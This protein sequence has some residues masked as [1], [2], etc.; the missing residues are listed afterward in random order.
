ME[1]EESSSWLVKQGFD[2]EP[3]KRKSGSR[4][5]LIERSASS[6]LY[7]LLNSKFHHRQLLFLVHGEF[8]HPSHLDAEHLYSA[9]LSEALHRREASNNW[10]GVVTEES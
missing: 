8:C 2:E 7:A 4:I 9:A 10:V 5:S 1:E 3:E 6:D